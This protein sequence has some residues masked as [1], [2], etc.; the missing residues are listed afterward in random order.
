M[1]GGEVGVHHTIPYFTITGGGVHIEGNTVQNV[2][3]GGVQHQFQVPLH[4]PDF[5]PSSTDW[6]PDFFLEGKVE[7]F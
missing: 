4:L 3:G 2:K 1:T 5:P 6:S 7:D